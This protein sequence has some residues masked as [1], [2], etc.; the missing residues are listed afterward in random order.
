MTPTEPGSGPSAW[1]R[2]WP[3]LLAT[4]LGVFIVAWAQYSFV[5]LRDADSYFHSR[6]AQ[7][8]GEQGIRKQFAQ[9]VFSTWSDSYS[10]KD[11]LFHLFLI[12]FQ[13]FE[14]LIDPPAQG[15]EDL[16]TPAKHAGVAL[17]LC[18]FTAMALSLRWVGARAV[19]LWLLVFIFTDVVVLKAML[20][21]RPGLLGTTFMLL[22]MGL[23]LT[24]RSR[25]LVLVGALHG[26]SH[27][28][29]ILLPGLAVATAAAHGLKGERIPWRTCA[30]AWAGP[31][32]TLV[33]NPYFPNNLSLTWTQLVEV[34]A[35]V[36]WGA[37]EIPASLFG[38]ELL[39]T[40][41]DL[42][43]GSWA[44]LL[45]PLAAVVAFLTRPERRLST[46]GLALLF[47]SA[48]L[49]SLAFMSERFFDFFF[50]AA[51]VFAA[52]AWT[53][54]FGQAP[55]RELWRD[56]R[57]EVRTVAALLALCMLA[58]QAQGGVA[59]LWVQARAM[60]TLEVQRP[61][62]EFL[63]RN[64]RPGELVYHNFWW[65]FS[66]LYHYRPQGRYVCALDPMFFYRHDPELFRKALA[67][68]NGES[69]DL[70]RVLRHDFDARWVYLP[71]SPAFFAFF[72]RM[73]GDARFQKAYEDDHVI[74]ARL[75]GG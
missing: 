34:G 35:A 67:A 26:L 41:T 73:R 75:P 40:R 66:I 45:P 2:E 25:W 46:G 48:M 61:A 74:I 72:N 12:P 20:A 70:Y 22:E 27:S 10:D 3:T 30:A 16:V 59:R 17:Y 4:L 62:V 53:D 32:L 23:L 47:M 65:D 54:F 50:P 7:E 69:E 55:R 5:G 14:R 44:A 64:A 31:A 6:A 60:V 57:A 13:G 15:A 1:R 24:R 71:K 18:F 38:P 36:W 63:V 51:I 42:F 33:V 9:T 56:R 39:A 8:I 37:A 19:G 43:L 21:I 11:L 68:Y 49:L 52:R 58:G 29:F 28:S